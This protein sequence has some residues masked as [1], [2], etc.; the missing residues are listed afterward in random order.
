MLTGPANQSQPAQARSNGKDILVWTQ[1][2]A[3]TPNR[4]NVFLRRG[5]STAIRLNTRGRG[6]NGDLTPPWVVYQ[7]VVGGKSDLKLYRLDTRKRVALPAGV[8][9]KHWEWRPRISGNWILFGRESVTSSRQT[10]LLVNRRTKA[11][12]T[13]ATI[14]GERQSARSRAD[15]GQLDR[16]AHVHAGLRRVPLRHRPADEAEARQ[17]DGRERA[18]PRVRARSQRRAASSTPARAPRA[19]GTARN[20]CGTA[21]PATRRRGRRSSRSRSEWTSAGRTPGARPTAASTCSIRAPTAARRSGSTSTGSPI[22]P[23]PRRRRPPRSASA[24]SSGRGRRPP[25]ARSRRRRDRAGRRA[26]PWSRDGSAEPSP[27]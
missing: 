20:S 2:A 3:A 26:T 27:A 16:L 12:R 1:A 5:T 13:L 11:K 22:R 10:L 8:N 14:T 25:R 23:R 18:D 7:Q 24:R 19:A 15:R 4:W 21:G 17:T 6:Y 9:T